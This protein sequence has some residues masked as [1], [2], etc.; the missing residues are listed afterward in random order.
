[1]GRELRML[2][3]N[4]AERFEDFADRLVELGLPGV[5]RQDF[6]K[7]RFELFVERGRHVFVSFLIKK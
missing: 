2:D 6:L 5:A 7:D 1:M 3:Q 4:R